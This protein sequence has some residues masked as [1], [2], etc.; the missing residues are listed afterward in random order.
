MLGIAIQRAP[1]IFSGPPRRTM[2]PAPCVSHDQ[3]WASPGAEHRR[4]RHSPCQRRQLDEVRP[5]IGALPMR[6]R[7]RLRFNVVALVSSLF[8]DAALICSGP[9]SASAIALAIDSVSDVAAAAPMIARR[10]THRRLALGS[11]SSGFCRRSVAAERPIA[12]RRFPHYQPASMPGRGW[13][14]DARYR[15][16]P[17]RMPA[18][19]Y[20]LMP[21]MP[22]AL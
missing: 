17:Q 12:R 13:S 6:R 5:F 3:Q 19:F 20:A 16:A 18:Y 7:S 4:P 2:M 11:G 22:A 15:Y 1:A 21:A 8:Q 10:A 9:G 14:H